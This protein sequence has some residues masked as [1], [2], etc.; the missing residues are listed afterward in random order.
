MRRGLLLLAAALVLAA[1]AVPFAGR[2]LV[3]ADPLPAT[4]DA[5][6]IMAG[7]IPDRVLEAADLYHAGVARRVVVTRERPLP[8]ERALRER[9]VR[10]PTDDELTLD[11]LVGLGVPAAAILRLRRHAFSTA[12][13]ARTIAR[14]ACGQGL[15]S[16]VVVTSPSHTRRARLILRRALGPTVRVAVRPSR[17]DT[18]PPERWWRIR[19]HA[20]VVLREYQQL[21]HHWLRERWRI[22]PCGGLRKRP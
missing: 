8:A 15:T 16:L 20:K 10:L 5:I 21:A 7:S 11:A 4:A 13:E 14:W 2:V 9:G 6:V 19:H 18:F 1:A 12:T 22:E 3:V 17:Y